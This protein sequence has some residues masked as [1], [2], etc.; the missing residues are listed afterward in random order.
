MTSSLERNVMRHHASNWRPMIVSTVILQRRTM[1]G[2]HATMLPKN[3]VIFLTSLHSQKSPKLRHKTLWRQAFDRSRYK[4]KIWT[5]LRN[6]PF[7]FEIHS[8]LSIYH[9]TT[10]RSKFVYNKSEIYITECCWYWF[11]INFCTS[12]NFNFVKI[13]KNGFPFKEIPG[14]FLFIL[15]PSDR[16]F[17][18]HCS[19]KFFL[20]P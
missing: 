9:R 12:F 8:K 10:T 4:Q 5:Q 1:P 19:H 11:W 15:L 7:G 2:L 16:F 20:A 17:S 13:S 6:F 3:D 18:S 14:L